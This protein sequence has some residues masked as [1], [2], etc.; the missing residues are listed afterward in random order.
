MPPTLP[1]SA[2]LANGTRV[3]I[4][5]IEREDRALVEEGFRHLSPRSRFLRF[6]S[7]KGG[8][9]ERELDKLTDTSDVDDIAIGAITIPDDET[10]PQPVGVARF[11]RFS[12]SDTRAE[13]ALTVVDGFQGAGAGSL[14]IETL[15]RVA[16][17]CNIARFIALVHRENAA[18]LALAGKYGAQTRSTGPEIE[19][20]M[21]VGQIVKRATQDVPQ[22]KTG[23]D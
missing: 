5:E 15:A 18:M 21:E 4:R 6:L 2:R 13:I 7:Q 17:G 16:S 20:S 8:L 1:I 14:L 11:V 3:M 19:L 23:P 9:S 22:R 10:S 12:H